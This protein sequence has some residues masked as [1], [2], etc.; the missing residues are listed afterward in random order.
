MRTLGP[1][2]ILTI[3]LKQVSRVLSQG[4]GELAG[5]REKM[6]RKMQSGPARVLAQEVQVF[7]AALRVDGGAR[8]ARTRVLNA[9]QER[10]LQR[11]RAGMSAR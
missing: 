10:L 9:A 2:V 6:P 1:A 11:A 7:S 8:K 3:P 5:E 4:L